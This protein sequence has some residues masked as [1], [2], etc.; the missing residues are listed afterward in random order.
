MTANKRLDSLVL[1]L[2]AGL[3][4]PVVTLSVIWLVSYE[5]GLV[6]FLSSFQRLGM[7]S[8]IISLSAIPN[9]LLFFVFI[10][11]NRTFSARGVI[12]ATLMV[13]MVML[14]LKFA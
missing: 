8:K 12:F 9:L 6:E 13:A 11:T 1:G 14:L 10:W 7:L 3:V 2:I 4:L 5:G